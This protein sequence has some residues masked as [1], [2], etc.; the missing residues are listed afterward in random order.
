MPIPG[1]ALPGFDFPDTNGDTCF[2]D[3]LSQF[4]GRMTRLQPH[5]SIRIMVNKFTCANKLA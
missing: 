3:A 1:L 5:Y 2:E 4:G